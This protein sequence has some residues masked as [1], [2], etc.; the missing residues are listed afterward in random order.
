MSLASQISLLATR[1]ATEVKAAK[2]RANHTGTQSVST[3]TGLGTMATQ[4]SSSVNITGGVVSGITPLAISDGGTGSNN[5][6]S[7]R[8]ALG[9]TVGPPYTTGS[10]APGS[11][12]VDG[13]EYYSTTLKRL[14]RS[15]GTSML[16]ISGKL[17][18]VYATKLTTQSFSSS[19]LTAVTFPDTELYDTDSL[20]STST[21]PSRFTVPAGMGGVWTVG[22]NV[23]FTTGGGEYEFYVSINGGA[24]KYHPS[25][26]EQSSGINMIGNCGDVVL[27]A[28]DYIEVFGKVNA[29]GRVFGSTTRESTFWA[30]YKGPQ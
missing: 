30:I 27:S 9:I 23:M 7:A 6:S 20:H 12:G 2:N 28:A 5:A 29:A 13:A 25:W 3:I 11:V 16:L 21:N 15:D 8:T 18:R 24:T 19:T 10:G 26:G 4:S 22:Y 17:P 1:I 14:Y